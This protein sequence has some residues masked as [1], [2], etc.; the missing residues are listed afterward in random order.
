MI[1]TAKR[2]CAPRPGRLLTSKIQIRAFKTQHDLDRFLNKQTDNSWTSVSM[3]GVE[4]SGFYA[5]LGGRYVNLKD[6]DASVLAH[7]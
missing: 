4:K 2:N 6:V 7:I 5:M 1:H 3:S